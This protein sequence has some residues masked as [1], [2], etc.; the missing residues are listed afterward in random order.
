MSKNI[1]ILTTPFRPN[2]GGVETHLDDLITAGTKRGFN[3]SILTYQPLITKAWGRTIEKGDGF[4]IYRLPW[5][6][7]NLFLIFVKFPLFE[8]L[9]LFPVFW[10]IRI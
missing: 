9:Y 4:I 5:I 2:I 10:K 8:L 1:L 7:M 3:F 6:R